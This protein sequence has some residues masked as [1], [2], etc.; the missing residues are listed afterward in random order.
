MTHEEELK[1]LEEKQ[2]KAAKEYEPWQKLQNTLYDTG[3]TYNQQMKLM[4]RSMNA[5][6]TFDELTPERQ[7]YCKGE[8]SPWEILNCMVEQKR[9]AY[10]AATDLYWD[11]HYEYEGWAVL[12]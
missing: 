6:K 3:L 10:E 2:N 5:I 1:M 11:K 12:A 9:E 7:E 8:E 4:F